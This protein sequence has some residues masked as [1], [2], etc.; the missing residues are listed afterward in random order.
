MVKLKE[1][2]LI[3]LGLLL[4]AL[5][6]Y[7]IAVPQNLVTGG[8]SGLSIVIN[9]IFPALS[10]GTVMLFLNLLLFIVGFIFIGF[11]FGA[12]TIYSSFALSGMV[13]LLE[14]IHPLSGTLTNDTLAEVLIASLLCSIGLAI[15]FSQNASTGGTDIIAKILNKYFDIDL[16]KAVLAADILIVLSSIFVFDISAGMYGIL[17]LLLNGL[18]IDYILQSLQSNKEIVIISRESNPIKDFIVTELER[19]ATIYSAKGAFTNNER[20][21]IRTIVSRKQYIKLKRYIQ[22]LDRDAFI[23]VNN[24]SVTYGEGF[25]N[26]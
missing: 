26:L 4:V 19:G 18:L 2:L 16:G 5:S 24:V 15:T 25:I 10:V 22:S 13:W 14:K 21:V 9:T 8:V 12:K 20:E 23:T 7:Y 17:G 1:F 11:N 6:I 3:N